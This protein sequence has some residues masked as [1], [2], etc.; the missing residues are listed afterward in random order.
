MTT[1]I[2]TATSTIAQV[3]ALRAQWEAATAISNAAHAAHDLPALAVALVAER[4]ARAAW[5]AAE[6]AVQAHWQAADEAAF[7]AHQCAQF[8]AMDNAIDYPT[9]L[10]IPYQLTSYGMTYLDHHYATNA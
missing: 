6:R 2:V 4:E 10:P 8:E 9:E 1:T 7:E 3:D 5:Q